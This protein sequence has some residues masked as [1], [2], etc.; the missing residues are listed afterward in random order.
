MEKQKLTWVILAVVLFVFGLFFLGSNRNYGSGCS[1]GTW[2]GGMM[3]WNNYGMMGYG[4]GN[5]FGGLVMIL[6]V[7]IL[8]LIATWILRQIN[9][10]SRGKKK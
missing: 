4:Y 2:S 8:V 9:S 10:N 3:G 5:F 1:F 6:V 7:L